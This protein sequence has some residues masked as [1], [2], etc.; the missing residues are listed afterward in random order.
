MSLDSNHKLINVIMD[1][2]LGPEDRRFVNWID[3]LCRRN[4][5]FQTKPVT[6]FLH[7]GV[8]YR[9]SNIAVAADVQKLLLHDELYGEMD[10]YLRDKAQVDLDRSQIK[11]ILFALLYPCQTQQDYRDALPDCIASVVPV[12]G[13][14]PRSGEALWSIK[15]NTRAL[16]QYAQIEARLEM[17]VAARIMY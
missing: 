4:Q 1:V 14:T 6:G 17:Y 9:P 12:I 10:I 2:L 15:D 5:E 11:Q 7:D 16:R 8:Y 13:H 3:Q